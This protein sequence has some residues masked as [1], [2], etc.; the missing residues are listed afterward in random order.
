[1]K[2][3]L[4]SV[5]AAALLAVA[6]PMALPRLVNWNDYRDELS[7]RVGEAAGRAVVF[8]GDL[9]LQ[10]LPAPALTA[11]DVRV[12]APAGFT[13][14]D[15]AT[16]KRL[17]V[18]IA[19]WPLLTGRIQ[20][21]SIVAVAPHMMVETDAAGRVNW[22]AAA[23]ETPAGG[24]ALGE[25]IGPLAQALSF[26]QIV[27][28]NGRLEIVDH[29]SGL[30]ETLDD[31]DLRVV[32]GS[33]TGPF[34][35]GGGLSWRGAP[36][37]LEATTGRFAGGAAAP[38]RLAVTLPGGDPERLS[39]ARFAGI[40]SP[41][42]PGPRLQG[43]LRLEGPNLH[44]AVRPMRAAPL[45]EKLARP[46]AFRATV[47]AD[48]ARVRLDNLEAMLGEA[49]G[50][51]SAALNL[52]ENV[53]LTVNL[54]FSRLELDPWL[55]PLIA[56][57]DG[58]TPPKR[59][60]TTA[61]PS[62]AGAAD[63]DGAVV[64]PEK[65][66]LKIE[67]AVD[68]AAYVG[69]T[70][71]QGRLTATA[72][73]NGVTV[74]RLSALIPGGGFAAT[75]RAAFAAT[76]RAA[77]AAGGAPLPPGDAPNADFRVEVNADNLRALLDWLRI[78]AAAVPADRLRKSAFA[79]RLTW[80][81]E[82][83]DAADGEI[84]LDGAK[85]TGALSAD[86]RA[87]PAFGLR[88][89][90]D[91]LDL[92]AYFPTAAATGEPAAPPAASSAAAAPSAT[93]APGDTPEAAVAR[94]LSRG[95]AALQ[96]HVQE[97]TFGGRVWRDAAL[98]AAAAG[99]GL[100]LRNAEI[101]DADGGKWRLTAQVA[102]F[103]PLTG[104]Q[105][106]L[107]GDVADL[108]AT[109]RRSGLAAEGLA[110]G[111]W[112][113]AAPAGPAHLR[114]RLAG[115]RDKLGVETLLSATGGRFELGGHIVKPLSLLG[116][117]PGNGGRVDLAARLARDD[118]DL[119][120]APWGFAAPA[121]PGPFDVYA[122]FNGDAHRLT[123]SDIKGMVGAAAITGSAKFDRKAVRPWV[124]ADLQTGVLDLDRLREKQNAPAPTA[125]AAQTADAQTA[126]AQAAA[127]PTA[128]LRRYDG[129]FALTA[130][131][132]RAAGLDFGNVAAK[133]HLTD[134]RLAV[135][136][137][138]AGQSGGRVGGQAVLSAA[139]GDRPA[140]LRF[141]ATAEG[142][143]PAGPISLGPFTVAGTVADAETDLTVSDPFAPAPLARLNGT[144]RLVAR[145]GALKGV[146]M[147]GL[148]DRLQR[149]DRPQVLVE[150]AMR[151]LQ[152]GETRIT[153]LDAGF[154][155]ENGV[156]ETVD[157]RLESPAGGVGAVGRVNLAARTLD[158]LL[159]VEPDTDP[160]FPPLVVRLTGP[161]DAPTRSL[162]LNALQRRLTERLGGAGAPD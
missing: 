45:S 131:G 58:K 18:R 115:D 37:R 90:A 162:D 81:G 70:L 27:L 75:G 10:L 69:G 61:K 55:P 87:R 44:A 77:F 135:D 161:L 14:A 23:G 11:A 121:A 47:E 72:D 3:L 68:A 149:A 98:D 127:D 152:G 136:R 156:A 114:L 32:A 112:T 109:L 142:L 57:A 145:G 93:I 35:A 113:T 9:G 54:L 4:I 130:A 146:D 67:A 158:M 76:G 51:G 103:A 124:E 13:R 160:P 85:L 31:I 48:D 137:F 8:D 155:I 120:F 26:D 20:V 119:L 79:G 33:L 7:R 24:V 154:T 41:E 1:L 111:G 5:S 122:K 92:D 49:R 159:T 126:D 65:L 97:L 133:A 147:A 110:A 88:L 12:K 64:W 82:R 101:Q 78:D 140:R 123:I 50:G 66:R 21:E 104:A 153:A 96:V 59:A 105:A 99:G 16:L 100:D 19:L 86:L 95:D 134:G 106:V 138:D 80:N 108:P 91:R 83:F 148:R 94:L 129:R 22:R 15:M 74:E 6:A 116:I 150:A 141:S 43:E 28:E 128:V 132:L 36:L 52:G 125:A 157:S 71:R 151:G 38:V 143:K 63:D 107:T 62:P 53:D 89:T 40:V 25:R 139:T 46:F 56:A 60:A 117:S 102:D 29:R 73:K 17:E 39:G 30:S 118:A 144:A 2:K 42:G 34:Q 84:E